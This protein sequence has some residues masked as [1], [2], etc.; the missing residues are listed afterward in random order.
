MSG[1]YVSDDESTW[2][3]RPDNNGLLVAKC[4]SD[5][6]R[7]SIFGFPTGEAGVYIFKSGSR[8]GKDGIETWMYGGQLIGT[9]SDAGIITMTKGNENVDSWKKTS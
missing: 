6:L 2:I 5:D 4:T 3:I 9:V 7:P 8:Y 1:T